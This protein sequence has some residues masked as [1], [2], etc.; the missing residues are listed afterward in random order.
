[1][2]GFV[3]EKD[4]NNIVTIT[5]DMTGPVNTMNAEFR[6]LFPQ[7]VERLEKERDN[8]AGVILASAKKTFF[9]GG[10]LKELVSIEKGGEEKF[11][12]EG[13]EMKS[14]LRRLECLGKPVVAAINGVALGGGYE[15]C[16][17]CHHRIAINNPQTLIGFPEVTLGLMPG[18]GGVVRLISK[19]GLEKALPFLM[20]GKRVSPDKAVKA[21]LIEEIADNK[22]D[23]MNKAIAW[24][25]ANPDAVQSWD[26][27]GYKIPGG[28]AKN[29][30][31][32][33]ML[34]MA[35]AMLR[36][37]TR[38]LMPA[39]EAILDVAAECLRV[40]FD[41]AQKI[42]SRSFTKLVVSPEAKNLINTFFFQMNE[43]NAGGSRPK[44]IEKSKVKKV[45]ILGAGMM[46]QG[47]AYVSAKAGMEVILKD[48]SI[49]AAQKGKAYS[50]KLL[51]KA[52]A[53]GRM[54]EGKKAAILDLI[55]P[56]A[57]DKD[58]K[59]CDLIVEAVFE[60]I[61]L[62]AQVTQ[63]TESF[64]AEDGIFGS[65][66][67]TLPI[68]GLAKAAARPDN[69]I[70][71][72]FFSPVERMPL[73]EIITGEKTSA[74][75][76]AKTFDYVQQIK[77]TPIVVNDSRGFFTSRVFTTFIEEGCKLLKEGIDPVLIDVLACQAGMPVGPLA[78]HDEISQ[79]LT[80]KAGRTNK[81]L[82]EARG[83]NYCNICTTTD[84]IVD[85]LIGEFDR[86]GKAYGGGHYEYPENRK[87]F[88]W[89]K[90]YDLYHKPEIKIP[91]Q[92]IKDRFLFRQV[93]ESLRC[94][95]EGVFNEVRDG[96]IGSIMGIGFPPHTGGV[97]QYIN[98][99]GIKEFLQRATE[100][101]K[102]YGERFEPP[103][104]LVKKSEHGE[105]FA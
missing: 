21:G 89:P 74:R 92:D 98:T 71:I 84:E 63:D 64:L 100:L 33:Q 15:V 18:A 60:S 59:G 65:N 55:K 103:A 39:P 13:L 72:H 46:G 40:D 58:L 14:F 67:S 80:R 91:H 101:A 51:T 42:E 2:N 70:G 94:L 82:D 87:K 54:D 37:K 93:I 66:T 27:K 9:A 86:R 50:E 75:T 96:N 38:G 28:N 56:T 26:K 49:E 5:M 35:P 12:K 24:I 10:D 47:I 6:T 32:I 41:T 19:I 8:I 20:E 11:F 69:F 76:L 43:L 68:S 17:A 36:K 73:V 57:D 22:E 52:I 61:E 78:I 90:L 77:K 95:E 99:Y 25:R 7:T 45:G 1:M 48:I 31:I 105:L 102:T 62:K 81:E 34:Q 3:Y 23:M 104:I 88:I 53:R 83:E 4:A 30:K 97:F 79:E 29:P 44:D 16:L 85:C